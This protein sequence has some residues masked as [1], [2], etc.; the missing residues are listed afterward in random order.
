M[1]VKIPAI[2]GRSDAAEYVRLMLRA[3]EDVYLDLNDI[4]VETFPSWNFYKVSVFRWSKCSLGCG[5]KEYRDTLWERHKQSIK[6]LFEIQSPEQITWRWTNDS[7][8]K[9]MEVE[10]KDGSICGVEFYIMKEKLK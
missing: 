1:K 4:E 9:G 8:Y 3:Y 5:D 6:N 10:S 2:M 7:K